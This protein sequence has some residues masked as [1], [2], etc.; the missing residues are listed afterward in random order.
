MARSY[1]PVSLKVCFMSTL[2]GSNPLNP[3][4]ET[5]KYSPDD[6]N[7]TQ[8]NVLA[9]RDLENEYNLFIAGPED[10]VAYIYDAGSGFIKLVF[11]AEKFFYIME[12]ASRRN[13]LNFFKNA[14]LPSIKE[15]NKFLALVDSSNLSGKDR[16]RAY[17]WMQ[18]LVKKQ[19]LKKL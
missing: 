17:T 1:L 10:E 13:K 4:Q 19:G 8:C 14:K 5:V 16:N 9:A 15:A 7:E 18:Q 6:M 2:I 3:W 11:D 12:N